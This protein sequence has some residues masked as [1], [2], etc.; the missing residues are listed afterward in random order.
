MK[1]T[2]N[3]TTEKMCFK[4]FSKRI[5]SLLCAWM[6]LVTAATSVAVSAV[7]TPNGEEP[8][9][10]NLI[11]DKVYELTPT[12]AYPDGV[13]PNDTGFA[14]EVT[15]YTGTAYNSVNSI[16]VYPFASS[17]DAKVTVNGESL[18]SSGYVQ[19]D[20][21][22]LGEHN[23]VVN[24]SQGD[25]SKT[26]TVNVIKVNSDYRGRTAIVNN[27]KIMNDISVETTVGDQAKLMEI[28]KKDYLVILPESSKADGSY[29]D[30]SESYWEVEASKLPDGQGTKAPTT[31]FT[32]DLGDVYSISRIRAAFGPS[33]L[34]LGQN[35]VKISVSAD[36]QKWETP[37]TKG[38]MCTGVQ[39]HQ[40][41]VRYELGVSYDTRYIKF[42]VTNWQY[43]NK[44]LRMYQF[45]IYTDSADVP[46]K[47][48]AP[49]GGD[50][51]YEH[52]EQ[53]QY[54]SS[55]QATVIERGLPMLGWTPSEGYGRGTPTVEESEQ[56]GYDGPLF[57]DPDFGNSDYM[58]YNP[59]SL[60]GIAKAPFGGNNMSSAGEP[61]D[62][63]PESMKDYIY[64][65]ISF[66]FGDEGYY[67]RSEAEAFGKWF[68]WTRE[69]YPGVILHTNQFPSQWNE[70]NLREYMT[71]A[72]PDML[73]WDDYY[74]DSSWANPSSIN[75][76]AENVQKAAARKLL[77]LPTWNLY[78][79]LASGGNDGTGSKP[80]MFGQYLDAFAFNHSQSNKN[81]VVNT[82][83]ISGMKWL[84][85]F[86]VEYQFDRSYFWDEDG[87]PTRGL[88]EWGEIID[89]VHAIDDQLTRLNSDWI[90]VK[91]GELGADDSASTDGFNRS[92][93]D[94][95]ESQ[96]KNKEYGLKDVAMVS[97]SDTHDGLTGDVLLG[98]FDTLP[99]LYESEIAEYFAGATAPKAFM[100]MNGLVA[101]QAERYNQ[102]NITAREAGSSDNTRQE[103]T[104]TVD[105]SFMGYDL[106]EVDKDNNGELKKVAVDE[107]GQF[108]IV[109]GGGEANLY[110]WKLDAK[111]TSTPAAAE[112]MYASFAFD[113]HS[114]TY[115]QPS[116]EAETYSLENSF[117]KSRF[118]EITITEKG[119]NITSI[120]VYYK[121]SDNQWVSLGD[122]AH[123]DSAWTFNSEELVKTTAL[124]FEVTSN[125][126]PAIYGVDSNLEIVDPN[127]VNVVTVNDN[128]MGDG[129]FRFDYDSLWSYRE[130][131]SN[132]SAVTYYPLENDGHFSNWTGA[133]ATFKFYGTKVELKLR[134]DQA[135][136]IRARVV[137]ENGEVITWKTGSGASL[138]FDGLEQGVYTL[139]IEK[140]NN[141]Q[142]GIDGA[143][144]TYKGEVPEDI[145]NEYNAGSKAVQI[146]INQNVTD[147]NEENRFEYTPALTISKQIGTDNSGFN[148]DADENSNWVEHIQNAMYQNLGFARTKSDG[149]SYTIH[150]KGTGVQL[151]GGITPMGDTSTSG[152]YGK[153]TFEL[154][155]EVV[156]PQTIDTSKLG[157]NGKISARMWYVPVENAK[158][159]EEHTLKVTVTGGYS[160]IDYAVV[161]RMWKDAH[162]HSGTLVSGK[163]ATCTE[164][165]V[166]DYYICSCDKYFEDAECTIEITNLDE[167]KVIPA[168]G[169]HFEDGVCTGCGAVL[170]DVNNSG[171]LE[172]AD[173]TAIQRYIV[174]SLAEG[175]EFDKLLADM[176][177][178]GTI[179]IIDA[180]LI[181]ISISK[182]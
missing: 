2:Q 15:S 66:C 105:P 153:L 176:N 17:E 156:E 88:L 3:K 96:L 168:T 137:D 59:D 37:V 57:Y 122:M 53:H 69:N 75:L 21:S 103:I 70:S 99:G 157:T 154:D 82:S 109:L 67:S 20:V 81:L 151:Y 166:K 106:Y 56:F 79:K 130:T 165:G 127:K 49:E 72:E 84:N 16:Q 80:I 76:S 33:N 149:A 139:E 107:N 126:L 63:I 136:N 116:A 164:P 4:G 41:V 62:F 26:Y 102:F 140:L 65:A 142:A 93:F 94:A 170:G 39:Y 146:Y 31:L 25:K 180:T 150:F 97:L 148:A 145:L 91:V 30:T 118:D 129:L 71:I 144:V 45:M 152:Q 167:W 132:K 121:N 101:G 178:D 133:K 46:E 174:G 29:V 28:L 19:M 98:Y 181:Q 54:I 47:Q 73:T 23:I 108:T 114:E 86:R 64:N 10:K 158:A 13:K 12:E 177:N 112:G 11:I 161:E 74:G 7:E 182:K 40:N 52:E 35:K 160:R 124:K 55:G 123:A 120:T 117:D 27:E 32:V 115:W 147:E 138:I 128:T 85:F 110:F 44:N 173:V 169:H 134:S 22:D 171:S 104:I 95:E 90:M 9:L 141:N 42:E 43:S 34:G 162:V 60:W 77:N 8:Y 48:P 61:T 1:K 113:N 92:N 78:R 100:V 111:A 38:N 50:V 179:S 143:T 24:V 131:E 36:G 5:I 18:N 163:P 51:P 159:N 155:G 89:R 14:P 6:L 68:D 58:L 125:G 119:N 83:L 172:V 135:S 87:T 175:P